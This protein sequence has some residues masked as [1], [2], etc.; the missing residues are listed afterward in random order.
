[1]Q[2]PIA[3]FELEKAPARTSVWNDNAFDALFNTAKQ[4][5]FSIALAIMLARWTGQRQG[6]VLNMKWSDI[7]DGHIHVRQH[8]TG[9]D[10]FVTIVPELAFMLNQARKNNS[11]DYIIINEETG[12]RYTGDNF[13]HWFKK[14]WTVAVKNNPGIDFSN[15]KFIDLRRTLITDLADHG[16]TDS[17]IRSI[18]G[19]SGNS[20]IVHSV[21]RQNTARQADNAM[22]KLI[23]LSVITNPA[24]EQAG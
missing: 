18:S 13:R 21:Y 8:K 24:F 10:V 22:N 12:K 16:C 6:D 17:E 14:I 5:R 15:L 9:V 11:S 2:N 19:H 20:R 3:L 4:S 7:A 1:M 23:G